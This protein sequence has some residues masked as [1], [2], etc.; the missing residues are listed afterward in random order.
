MK[1]LR[2]VPIVGALALA[3]CAQPVRVDVPPPVESP[4]KD[5]A[6][7]SNVTVIGEAG[8]R[9]TSLQQSDTP[10]PPNGGAAI[11][12]V[13]TTAG[14]PPLRGQPI[15]VN[16]EA[17]PVPTFINEFFGNV[18]KTTFQ[19]DPAVAKMTDL[20]TLRT[21]G[22][23]AP[24]DFYRLATRVLQTY[25]VSTSYE[26]GRLF[27]TRDA[28]GTTFEPPLFMSGRALPEVPVSHRPVFQ[29]VELQSVRTS[30]VNQWLRT[31]FKTDALE[32]QDD[33]NRNAVVLY[34]RPDI[35]AQA[36]AAIRV[37]DRPYMRGRVSTR[38]EPAFVS[39]DELGRRLVDVLVAEGYGASLHT[40]QGVVQSAAVIV[41]PIAQANTVLVFAAERAVLDHAIE[42]AQTIDRPNPTASGN[43]L[44]YYQVQNTRAEDIVATLGGVRAAASNAAAAQSVSGQT[45]TAGAPAPTSTTA[46]APQP[47]SGGAVAGANQLVLDAPRN[48]IIFQGTAAD[49]S[50]LLPL[51][52]QMDRA[53][54]QVMIEVT[55]A[56]VTLDNNQEFGVS[57]LAKSANLGRFHGT[58]TSGTLG[59][60]NSGS[61]SG[62]A[63]KVFS[64]LTYLLD[65]GGE[66][67]AQLKAYAEDN[68]LTVLS[69]PRL[70]VKSG[71]EASIDVG[72]EVPT[73]T[74]QTASVQ[75][76]EGTSNLLQS[77]EYRKT[78]IILN[79]QP[80]VYS[81]NRIDLK[82]RQEVSEALP[83]SANE[84]VK[85]PS[86]FNRS[87]STNL[88]LRDGSAI[89][90]GGLMSSRQNNGTSGVPLL[91]D[92]P[93]VGNLFKTQTR[94]RTRTELVLMIVP[95][96]VESDTQAA[97]LTRSIGDRLDLI[98]LPAQSGAPVGPK[99]LP[100]RPKGQ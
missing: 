72:T 56:E 55:I 7:S 17:V 93:L 71:E 8:R 63:A 20:V 30:D 95:Y 9:P 6:N 67:R 69:T 59:S 74:T 5:A 100:P 39:A 76:T 75:Q 87:V 97:A 52:K 98:D 99:P 25:G 66:A 57:W 65:V 51:V 33:L 28:K 89:L 32:I 64:G 11:S 29:L 19:M 53:A 85:S 43:S 88:S 1:T 44:F 54:R 79:I 61:G 83:L 70:M 27:F 14:I 96:I 13:S 24:Q 84:A 23:Q 38:L 22:P 16:I 41:L 77:I 48:G 35:V 4:R 50:R 42:W 78:G 90:I 45:I 80:I 86:I 82:V 12:G 10:V 2:V 92:V 31:A 58:V 21:S 62:T 68:R 49:W 94:G 18:L 26:S 37:L 81:D 40:G 34:G 15:N 60:G 73:V 36:A 91:K 3:A 46:V 47:T